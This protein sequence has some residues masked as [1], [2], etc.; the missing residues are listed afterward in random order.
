MRSLV[1][2][3]S[4]A[5]LIGAF[6]CS[7]E[8]GDLVSSLPTLPEITEAQL[9][10]VEHYTHVNLSWTYADADLMDDDDVYNV[11][12]G[13]RVAYGPSVFDTLS[14]SPV[15]STTEPTASSFSSTVCS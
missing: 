14:T 9:G 2:Y 15:A 8:H 11:Y 4:L 1:L 5:M 12:V 6:G 3:L 13:L 7:T 10:G